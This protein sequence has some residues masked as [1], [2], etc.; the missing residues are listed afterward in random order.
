[1]EQK[2]FR[3]EYVYKILWHL[4]RLMPTRDS[5][6]AEFGHWN[7]GALTTHDASTHEKRRSEP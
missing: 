7:V 3:N 1:M 2:R 6:F 5:S 4:I